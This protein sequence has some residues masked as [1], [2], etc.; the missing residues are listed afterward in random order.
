MEGSEASGNAGR[1]IGGKK[2]ESADE[3]RV[4][5]ESL[6]AVLERCQRALEMLKNADD[7][8]SGSISPNLPD[9]IDDDSSSVSSQC[10]STGGDSDTAELC[11]LLKSRVESPTFLEK[12]GSMHVSAS[13]NITDESSS[14]DLISKT[15]W[16]DELD[17]DGYVLVRQEDIV[18]GIAC[19]MAAYLL[20]LKQTKEL[21]PAQL[22]EGEFI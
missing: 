4:R 12:L 9:E 18:E 21:T 8:A 1:A 16:D 3:V 22:Q 7:E 13:Q 20:S 15:D 14:W 10:G 5:R 11:D 17:Q 19:F 2:R 6:Q